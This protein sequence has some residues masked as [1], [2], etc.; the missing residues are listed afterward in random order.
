VDGSAGRL[1]LVGMLT[2]SILLTAVLASPPTSPPTDV[3]PPD[4]SPTRAEVSFDATDTMEILVFDHRGAMVGAL[5][6]TATADNVTIDASF[7]DGYASFAVT[8]DDTSPPNPIDSDLPPDDAVGRVSEMLAIAA[9][10]VVEVQEA[11]RRECMWIF[12]GI[13]GGCGLAAALTPTGIPG[14][15]AAWDCMMGFG[16]GLCACS[17]HLPLKIC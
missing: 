4:F 17:E 8:L 15:I 16:A 6:A 13:A 3:A 14:A 5:L 11:S 9:P 12:A 1:S 2:Q 7:R 10:H